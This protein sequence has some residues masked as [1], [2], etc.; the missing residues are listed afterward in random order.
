MPTKSKL[1]EDLDWLTERVSNRVW[2]I[3]VGVLA[4]CLTYII[5]SLKADGV[6]F[7]HPQQVTMPMA[8][9]L[10]ALV[11]D[12]MQYFAA[13]KQ[14]GALLAKMEKDGSDSRMYNKKSFFYRL[15]EFSFNAKFYLAGA[16]VLWLIA[17]SGLRV[18]E[19]LLG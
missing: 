10:L 7:L 4:T 15:R 16:A 11:F 14:S 3:S 6:P 9:A 8:L 12:L 1:M 5:E 19:I 13:I 18:R 2:T 17:I